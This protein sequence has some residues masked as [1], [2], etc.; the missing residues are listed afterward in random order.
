MI[1]RLLFA[2]LMSF[3]FQASAQLR[4]ERD[5][6]AQA[7]FRKLHFFAEGRGMHMSPNLIGAYNFIGDLRLIQSQMVRRWGFVFDEGKLVGLS[8]S[9][10]KGMRIG[11]IG[12]AACH[13]GKAAG[14]VIV[15]LGNKNI[16][17]VRLATDVHR[18]EQVWKAINGPEYLK[19]ADYKDVEASA[20]NFSSYLASP[21]IGN[22][23]QGL[24]PVS[25]IRGWFYR[26]QNLPVPMTMPRGQVKIPSMWGYELKRNLGQFCDGYGNGELAGWAIAVELAAGQRH[27]IVRKYFDRVEKAELLFND[28]LPPPYPFEIDH[29]RAVQGEAVFAQTCA[30]CHGTYERD[31]EGLPIFQAPRFVPW[32]VVATDS[33]RLDGNTPEFN[34]LVSR[35]P[36]SDVVRFTDLGRGYFAPRLN[37]I[38][39][40]FPYLHNGSVPSIRALLEPP[41]ARPAAFTLTDAGEKYRF[42]PSALGLR[43]TEA[44]RSVAY[45]ARRGD[46]DVYDVTRVGHSNQGHDFYT[47]LPRESKDALIEYLKTL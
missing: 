30:R 11:V 35:S 44:A 17:V 41:A 3:S 46:R 45:R 22:L 12:C 43:E 28:F 38:W 10:Y 4:T 34:D 29:A 1:H 20:L 18:L 13:T 2:I 27:Q 19:S 37:G 7:A 47:S 33:D 39:S 23:T 42:D 36:L 32:H 5:Q 16:D 21:Q 26:M 25:F 40:R 9:A 8:E 15:G 31:A 24:V 14:Q 6:Q